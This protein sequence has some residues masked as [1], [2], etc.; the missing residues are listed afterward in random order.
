MAFL[1]Y[2]QVSD[3][4]LEERKGNL[5]CSVF[6]KAKWHHHRCMRLARDCSRDE[7]V[8]WPRLAPKREVP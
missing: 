6:N 1:Q 3:L 7:G 2:F 5:Y 4:D 8:R